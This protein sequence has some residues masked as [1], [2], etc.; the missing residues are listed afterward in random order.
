MIV[1]G[2]ATVRSCRP[3]A[4]RLAR[5]YVEDLRQFRRLLLQLVAI[6]A[7]NGVL[8]VLVAVLWGRQFLSIMYRPEYAIYPS[9]FVWLMVAAGV[10]YVASALSF[11]LSAARKFDV[12]LP[13]Y[14]CAVLVTLAACIPLVPHYG[15]RGAAWALLSRDTDLVYRFHFGA[16]LRIAPTES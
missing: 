5:Y 1:G 16:G 14:V 12:Q 10:S 6:A 7:A 3:A 15:L 8:G 9:V 11:G 2:M 13:I 4:A